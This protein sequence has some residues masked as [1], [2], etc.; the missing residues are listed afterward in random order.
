M[1]FG[2]EWIYSLDDKVAFYGEHGVAEGVQE[3]TLL[4]CLL[5]STYIWKQLNPEQ[6][7]WIKLWIG[8]AVFGCLYVFG[9]EISWGQKFFGWN[10]PETWAQINTQAETNIHNTS[11]IFNRIPRTILEVGILVAGLIIPALNKW[12]PH[13]LP[14]KFA[15]IYAANAVAFLA[16]V[17]LFIKILEQFPGWFD[18][19]VF[20]RKSEVIETFFYYFVFLYLLSI[21]GKWKTENRL[22]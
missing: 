22:V 3:T 11:Q 9:E 4:I 8:V 20:Y 1:F 17:T 10:T 18:I 15:P 14:Q 7:K 19:Q 2:V 12:A 6:N 21:W 13:K 5:F 16:S